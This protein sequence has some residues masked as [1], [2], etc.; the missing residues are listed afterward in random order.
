MK[1]YEVSFKIRLLAFLVLVSFTMT[2]CWLPQSPEPAPSA[3]EPVPVTPGPSV[4]SS[5]AVHSLAFYIGDDYQPSEEDTGKTAYLLE[6]EDAPKDFVITSEDLDD[7][8]GV[9]R[10][11]DG[12]SGTAVSVYFDAGKAF[13]SL[14]IINNE[15]DAEDRVYGTFS[16]YDYDEEMFPSPCGA[17]RKSTPLKGTR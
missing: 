2:T 12:E 5:S 3:R 13:P 14:F 15:E 7:G 11:L 17:G 1:K 4:L 10:F 8:K 6:G 16:E 9:A